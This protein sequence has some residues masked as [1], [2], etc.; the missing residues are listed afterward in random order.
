MLAVYVTLLHG[1]MRAGSA[2]DLALTREGD[3]GE[4]P[5][6]PARMVSALVAA[7]GTRGRCRVTP[8]AELAL[9][10]EARPPRIYASPPASVLRSPQAARF[11]VINTRDDGTVQGYPARQAQ[12]VR[13]GTRL[14]PADARVAYVWDD[15]EP[16]DREM[17]ALRA[18]AA[19]VGY[20]GCADSP[21]RVTVA[22]ELDPTST[23]ATVWQPD[24]AGAETL[25]VPFPGYID[26]LDHI[27]DCWTSGQPVRRAWFRTQLARYR[28]PGERPSVSAEA[29]WAT[30]IW[31][32]FDESLPGRAALRVAETLK[33]AVLDLYQRHSASASGTVPSVLH[34]HRAEGERGYQLAQWLVLP[35]VGHRHASGRLHGAA[36]M[37]PRVDS[38][39]GEG[40][41]YAVHHLRELVVP[42]LPGVRVRPHGDEPRPI[43][44]RPS[45][46]TG[47]SRRWQSVFPVIHERRR[48][49]GPTLDDAAA[50][51]QH[52]GVPAPARARFSPTPFLP[53]TPSLAPGEVFRDRPSARR[54]YSYLELEFDREIA[55]P[56]ALG[57]GRQ[58]GMGL[59][60]PLDGAPGGRRA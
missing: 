14:C 51:C 30:T 31:L 59:M 15:L 10:E 28:R 48:R 41:R 54:P 35:D 8:S 52:A 12:A 22:R 5:P 45:R 57:R 49:H 11:V 1:H 44:A 4:W 46:W 29:I 17:A 26:V 19:R 16:T 7:D 36:I 38:E 39:V 21:V 43:A 25:P 27:F 18:R 40:V 34:G 3:P 42:G 55:G 2:D 24:D 20:L 53:G 47:P 33:A 37:L 32:R 13:P 23:P 60:A 9:F 6:S 50:W 56:V 58:F